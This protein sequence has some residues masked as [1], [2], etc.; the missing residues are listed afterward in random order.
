MARSARTLHDL[1]R[2]LRRV[3]LEL[4]SIGRAAAPSEREKLRGVR[5]TLR[6]LARSAGRARDPY[7]QASV[8]RRIRAK[9]D[10]ERASA[11]ARGW[12]AE[13]T[14]RGRRG[15]VDL[16]RAITAAGR[17]GLAAQLRDVARALEAGGGDGLRAPAWGRE[18]DRFTGQVETAFGRAR[19]RPSVRRLHRLRQSIREA[20]MFDELTGP[21]RAGPAPAPPAEVVRLQARLGR[22]HD[23]SELRTAVDRPPPAPD[24]DPARRAL[25]RA[26]LHLAARLG[27]TVRDPGTARRLSAWR[28]ASRPSGPTARPRSARGRTQGRSGP[29]PRT[30]GPSRRA[31]PGTVRR[32]RPRP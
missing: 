4:G 21:S 22:L 12:V 32:R 27:R 18:A 24:H 13:L 31:G 9:R 17:S 3:A 29:P 14:R 26:Y 20:R 23:L 10:G 16:R 5:R 6:R 28:R 30:P 8:L 25:E 15:R 2:E 7:V 19:R 11:W 1:H